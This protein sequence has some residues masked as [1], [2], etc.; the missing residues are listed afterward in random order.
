[1][2]SLD[3]IRGRHF[4]HLGDEKVEGSWNNNLEHNGYYIHYLKYDGNMAAK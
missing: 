1:M 4:H 2:F 3:M